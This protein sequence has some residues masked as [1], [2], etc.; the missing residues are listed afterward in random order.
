MSQEIEYRDS[1]RLFVRE[2]SL[3]EQIAE[4][5]AYPVGDESLITDS[6]AVMVLEYVKR[7]VDTDLKRI[8]EKDALRD[9]VA[10]QEK[11]IERLRQ[12][13]EMAL[14]DLRCWRDTDAIYIL[15]GTLAKDVTK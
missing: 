15:S 14:R 8:E 2:L 12:A 11:E 5:L 7:T 1:G 6:N 4:A 10:R 3:K 13:M 9:T